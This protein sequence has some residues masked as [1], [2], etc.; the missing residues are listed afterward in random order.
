LNGWPGGFVAGKILIGAAALALVGCAKKIEGEAVYAAADC[1]QATILDKDTGATVIGAEDLVYDAMARRVIISAYDRRRVEKEASKRAY[2]ISQ[3]GVYALSMDDLESD[4]TVFP[5]SSI[6]SRE[7]VA[8]G[9]RPHG[10]AFDAER[11]EI[12]FVNRSYQRINGEWRM[13]PRIERAGA[14]GA[15]FIGDGGRP[16]CS[17]NDVALLGDRT[18]VSFDHADCGWRGSVEDIAALPVSGVDLTNVGA[19]FSGARH[20]N[21]VAATHDRGLAL[22]ATR[23]SAVYL[24]AE[25]SGALEVEKKVEL[26]GGPDNL[27]VSSNGSII[28]A[29]YPSLAAI[30]VQRKLGVGRSASRIVRIDPET[31]ETTL[32]FE[33]PKA[34]SFSA[35]S[36][37]VEEEGIL[38]IGS[39]LDRGVLICKNDA[40]GS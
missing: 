21:G 14:D 32:L 1:R 24:L 6:V 40:G 30:G 10:I 7:S 38:V 2:E 22:A 29:L 5:L 23:D 16:R 3:G 28:A 25:K 9:L 37:A 4:A 26:P 20:A 18:F 12:T 17:A 39:A 35:A 15:V 34:K 36:A 19:V 27:T 33:D 11:R 8:G 31:G 13:T